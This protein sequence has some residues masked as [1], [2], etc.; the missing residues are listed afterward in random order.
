[1]ATTLKVGWVGYLS[2]Y[3]LP[4]PNK[5]SF[6]NHAKTLSL[7]HPTVVCLRESN[8]FFFGTI[9]FKIDPYGWWQTSLGD[10]FAL[11]SLQLVQ[12][13]Q[14]LG[15]HTEPCPVSWVANSVEV[16]EFQDVLG[17]KRGRRCGIFLELRGFLSFM[18]SGSRKSSSVCSEWPRRELKTLKKNITLRLIVAL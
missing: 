14:V 5:Q 18:N 11:W 12:R 8:T 2:N 3:V 17:K 9:F 13:R 4:L 10:D 15:L 1:M 6:R 16:A 7:R